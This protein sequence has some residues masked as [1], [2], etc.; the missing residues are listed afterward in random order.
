M[1]GD[2]LRQ[3]ST[4]QLRSF[5]N[6]RLLLAASTLISFLVLFE[7]DASIKTWVAVAALALCGFC[8]FQALRA[9]MELRSRQE[10]TPARQENTTKEP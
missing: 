1:N 4:V 2:K 8:V 10:N 3:S 9:W 6:I 7:W 5:R